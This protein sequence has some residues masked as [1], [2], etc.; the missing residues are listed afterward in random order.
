[1]DSDHSTYD[2]PEDP[3]DTKGKAWSYLIGGLVVLVILYF[4]ASSNVQVF[5]G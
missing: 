5:G 4:V 1:M 3:E 2:G